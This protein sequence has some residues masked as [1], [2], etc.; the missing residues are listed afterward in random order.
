[1]NDVTPNEK[2]HELVDRWKREYEARKAGNAEMRA[3]G[4]A[5]DNCADEL[6]EVIDN[7]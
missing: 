5:H 1:M 4:M 6:R 7:E 3:W 2:L